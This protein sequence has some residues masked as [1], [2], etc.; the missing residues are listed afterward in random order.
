MLL[1]L[2]FLVVGFGAGNG[3]RELISRQRRRAAQSTFN[4]P[5]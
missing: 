1:H 5:E 3:L 2:V 4:Y